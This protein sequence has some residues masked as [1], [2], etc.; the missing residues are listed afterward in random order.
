MS[1]PMVRA[2]VDGRKTVTRRV[3]KHAHPDAIA[4]QQPA[5]FEAFLERDE[6]APVLRKQTDEGLA[7][8]LSVTD[9]TIIRAPF[10]AGDVVYVKER[11]WL[12]E[13]EEDCPGV[14]YSDGGFKRIPNDPSVVEEW[15]RRFHDTSVGMR[16]SLFMPEWASRLRLLI[17]NVTVE[18]LHDITEADAAAEGVERLILQEGPDFG[19]VNGV[20][21]RGHPLT[22]SYRD[23]YRALWDSLNADRGH[24]WDSNP[25]VWRIEFEVPEGEVQA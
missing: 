4:Y 15:A 14:K 22:S 7:A 6:F 10:S 2:L 18:R 21:Q 17:T 8:I 23:A 9:E 3:T 12:E 13:D 5:A 16:P 11:W 25:W 20:P 24:P 19:D 1:G